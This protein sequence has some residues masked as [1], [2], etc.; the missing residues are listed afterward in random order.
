MTKTVKRVLL[1]A[2]AIAVA[3]IAATSGTLFATDYQAPFQALAEERGSDDALPAAVLSSPVAQHDL[4]DP[5]TAR[6]VGSYSGRTYWLMR[7]LEDRV[8]LVSYKAPES[9][10]AMCPRTQDGGLKSLVASARPEADGSRTVVV[11]APDGYD[12]LTLR[13]EGGRTLSVPVVDNVGFVTTNRAAELSL[14]GGAAE[15]LSVS[16]PRSLFR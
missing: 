2:I 7:G 5:E 8:C 6:R 1:V 10:G 4:G 12:E 15:Q 13:E 16:I 11:L 9:V 3:A 14:G